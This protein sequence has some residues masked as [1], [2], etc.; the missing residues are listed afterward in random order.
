M[1]RKRT[2]SLIW[3][4]KQWSARVAGGALVPLLVSDKRVARARL[5]ELVEKGSAPTAPIET[6]EAAAR[7]I[8]AALDA[9]G[10][11]TADERLSRL[12]RFAFPTLGTLLVTEVKPGL[13]SALLEDVASKGK[14]RQTII[15]LRND[16]GKVFAELIRDE[17]L[18]NNP[19]KA[20]RVRTPR[21][22]KDPRKRALLTDTEFL[23]VV[24]APTTREQVRVMATCSRGFGGMRTSDLHEWR[25]TD[26][27]LVGWV[28]S[29]IPRPKTEHSEAVAPRERIAIPSEV[30][31]VLH[32]WWVGQGSP[33]V[34]P[35]FPLPS[36]RPRKTPG[37]R[38]RLVPSYARE[39]RAALLAAGVDRHELHHPTATTK[40]VDFH[41]F[42]R[43]FVTAVGAAGLNAQTAMRLTG[44][45][46][47][48]THMRYNLPDLLTIP[49]AAVPRAPEH[50][51][52]TDWEKAIALFNPE[53]PVEG[54]SVFYER[55]Q[56]DL[57]PCYRRERPASKFGTRLNSGES[58][59]RCDIAS[60]IELNDV[61]RNRLQLRPDAR[62]GEVVASKLSLQTAAGDALQAYLRGLADAIAAIL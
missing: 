25:W 26:V 19:A 54:P 56:R 11:V 43:A 37:R 30:L 34:G 15:H 18:V 27:D 2:G 48:A 57:N 33:S 50:A 46:S 49:D 51:G 53:T 12:E 20:E 1:P 45:R 62:L 22:A 41:S 59:D 24:Q 32:A 42:R 38:Q 10:M 61:V 60:V 8:V 28:H 17:V 13:I 52:E 3:T 44:H 16:L 5:R 4:G 31:D 21:V 55:P 14:S 47:M 40:P 39:L 29:D 6:L 23:K 9:D 36:R 58:A 7:R 35:V